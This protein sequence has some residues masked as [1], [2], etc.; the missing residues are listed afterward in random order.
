ME[1]LW[2]TI[3]P[4]YRSI[5]R[6][7][8]NR[9]STDIR[10]MLDRLLSI[11]SIL[12]RYSNR[13]MCRLGND[14][15]S[16]HK[17]RMQTCNMDHTRK[18]C[19]TALPNMVNESQKYAKSSDF[20]EIWSVL[21]RRNCYVLLELFCPDFEEKAWETLETCL[22]ENTILSSE[23]DLLWGVVGTEYVFLQKLL[24]QVIN[25]LGKSQIL[26][27]NSVRVLESGPRSY[28]DSCRFIITSKTPATIT[29]VSRVLTGQ[30]SLVYRK[31]EYK[32]HNWWNN[33]KTKCNMNGPLLNQCIQA[34][35]FI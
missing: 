24:F 29:A 6:S 1:S 5:C 21:L 9:H 4:I 15:W 22:G 35:Q 19:V 7:L 27:I 13:Y 11:L 20:W 3:R 23:G 30:H 17:I 16:T 10:R 31:R 26:V 28:A 34:K 12:G 18:A 2:L 33:A 32:R 14:G 25:R 8:L